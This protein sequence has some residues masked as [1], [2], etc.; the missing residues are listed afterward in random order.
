MAEFNMMYREKTNGWSQY[1][2]FSHLS[3]HYTSYWLQPFVFSLY[4]YWL[5]PFVLSLY[6]T[7]GWSQY[8]VSWE[9]RWLKSIW[10]IV[11]RQMAEVNMMCSEKTNGCHDTSYWLQPFDL[12][13][14]IILT[15]AICLLTIHHIEFSH[16]S[17]HYTSYWLQ[18]F[19]FSLYIILSIVRRQM[20]EVNMMCSEK[21]NGW[22]Q[23]DVYWEDKWLRSIWCI[24]V[25][26]LYIILTSAIYLLTIH[27]ID[28]SQ[29][30]SHYT[31]YWLQPSCIV[32]GQM[33]EVNMMY[34]EKTNGWSQ[35]D[36]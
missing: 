32:R 33:A 36:V 24:V 26:S 13:L 17:S 25:F 7:N 22:S 30:S 4:I 21:T 5:Q 35:Y 8:D 34:S 28:F 10:C 11:R 15:W 6:K 23:Y 1:I 31:S 29:L 27:H 3:S 9:D 20:A 14:H 18:P 19:V 2:D 16:L 12:S